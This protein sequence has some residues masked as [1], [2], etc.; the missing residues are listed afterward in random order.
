MNRNRPLSP[1]NPAVI[2]EGASSFWE[3]IRDSYDQAVGS[4]I[5][6]LQEQDW[7]AASVALGTLLLEP[8]SSIRAGFEYLFYGCFTKA[9][10]SNIDP[11]ELTN[12][13]LALNPVLCLHGNYHAPTAFTR[14]AKTLRNN[15]K[16][17]PAVFTLDLNSG[18]IT[19]EDFERINAKIDQIK[20]LYGQRGIKDVKIDLVGHSRGANLSNQM[21]YRRPGDIGRVVLMGYYTPDVPEQGAIFLINGTR[22][23]LIRAGV[24]AVD[25]IAQDNPA[26]ACMLNTG[27]LGLLY[28]ADAKIVE[29]LK[30]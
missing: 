1:H 27:H 2:L 22:E 23:R 3:K 7:Y 13:Q 4:F 10:F 9:R 30:A 11:K 8:I 6:F 12:E 18:A 19:D 21:Y 24:Q 5:D 14:I 28:E 15:P 20:D 25:R 29:I 17:R 26:R 16:Y